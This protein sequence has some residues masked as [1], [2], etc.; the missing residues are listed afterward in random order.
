[1]G[2]ELSVLSPDCTDGWVIGAR[3]SV[4][5][6][7]FGETTQDLVRTAFHVALPDDRAYISERAECTKRAT[8]TSP[9]CL[10]FVGP[11]GTIALRD[12]RLGAARVVVPKATM[13]EHRPLATSIRRIRRSRQI[14]V[15][16]SKAEACFV[17]QAANCLFRRGVAL[18]HATKTSGCCS[19]RDECRVPRS[20]TA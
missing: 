13:D 19:V 14:A 7:R 15:P 17:Q 10:E 11:E 20:S 16:S 5:R 8:V 2:H 1:M 3:A 9:V 6:E 18:P 12:R 4:R